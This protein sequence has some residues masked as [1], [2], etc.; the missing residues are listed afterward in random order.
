[1]RTSVAIIIR[2]R[3]GVLRC[4]DC[5]CGKYFSVVNHVV[6]KSVNRAGRGVSYK[7]CNI[8]MPSQSL[9]TA[10]LEGEGGRHIINYAMLTDL[11][12]HSILE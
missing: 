7:I 10:D 11:C 9:F 2:T 12:A 6:P 1:M 3:C 4:V 5:L 8:G